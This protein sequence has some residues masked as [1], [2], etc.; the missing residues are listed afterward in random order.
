DKNEAKIDIYVRLNM[1]ID[2]V[3]RIRLHK[4][5]KLGEDNLD[6]EVRKVV[7]SC[8][9][10]CYSNMTGKEAAMNIDNIKLLEC[11]YKKIIDCSFIKAFDI[12]VLHA[13]ITT[14]RYVN[15]DK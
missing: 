11:F 15:P 10:S 7:K 9:I 14:L 8:I 1:P 3:E 4:F 12:Y 6:V 13:D 5:V 2:D